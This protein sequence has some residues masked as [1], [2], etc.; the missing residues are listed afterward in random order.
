M[1]FDLFFLV[2]NK[3]RQLLE[4]AVKIDIAFSCFEL[5]KNLNF[6]M[7]KRPPRGRMIELEAGRS[8]RFRSV[9]LNG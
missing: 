3:K 2:K 8:G 5:K 1:F 6:E 4:K 9:P 7:I